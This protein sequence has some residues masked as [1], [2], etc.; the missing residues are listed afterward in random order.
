VLRLRAQSVNGKLYS[1]HVLECGHNKVLPFANVV[2][3]TEPCWECFVE[4]GL[5]EED[6]NK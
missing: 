5:R 2:N 6:K 4:A 3:E 1:I